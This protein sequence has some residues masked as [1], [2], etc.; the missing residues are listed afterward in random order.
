MNF[1]G[2]LFPRVWRV[3]TFIKAAVSPFQKNSP[4]LALMKLDLSR[5]L[6]GLGVETRYG[7]VNALRLSF[8]KQPGFSRRTR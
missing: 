1:D 2:G 8:R 7:Q 5:R 6:F 4:D 3:E